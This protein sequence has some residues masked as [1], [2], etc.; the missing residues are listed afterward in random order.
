[1]NELVD[2]VLIKPGFS[3]SNYVRCGNPKWLAEG[4]GGLIY[5]QSKIILIYVLSVPPPLSPP[6]SNKERLDAGTLVVSLYYDCIHETQSEIFVRCSSSGFISTEK[7]S[8]GLF[9]LKNFY[10]TFSTGK[11]LR[12]FFN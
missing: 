5:V 6:T 12:D 9:Q 4:K 10:G 1:M 11:F 8:T 3:F 7:N 2:C